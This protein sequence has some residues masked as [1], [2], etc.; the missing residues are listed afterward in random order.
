MGFGKY[1]LPLVLGASLI[2][3]CGN[4]KPKLQY[5]KS[6]ETSEARFG[7]AAGTYDIDKNGQPDGLSIHKDMTLRLRFYDPKRMSL[8]DGP[9]VIAKLEDRGAALPIGARF[10]P[11]NNGPNILVKYTDDKVLVY[12]QK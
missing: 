6:G 11:T 3:G 1:V 9:Q 8:G 7:S 2:G 12:T 5:V 4:F 10:E